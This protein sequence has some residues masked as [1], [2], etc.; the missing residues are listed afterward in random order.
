M[1]E[2]RICKEKQEIWIIWRYSVDPGTQ[3]RLEDELLLLQNNS[4]TINLNLPHIGAGLF[5]GV[6]TWVISRHQSNLT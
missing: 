5:W 6:M 3:L 2:I 1:T 4:Y